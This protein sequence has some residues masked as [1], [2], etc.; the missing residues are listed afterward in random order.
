M[1]QYMK[2][3]SSVVRQQ[4]RS[5]SSYVVILLRVLLVSLHVVTVNQTLN[6]LLQISRLHNTRSIAEYEKHEVNG[7]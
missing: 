1:T 2:R 6:T 7:N 4:R 3:A 5:M